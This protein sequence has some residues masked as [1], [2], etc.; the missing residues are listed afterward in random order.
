M[1]DLPRDV[2]PRV[3]AAESTALVDGNTA[4]AVDAYRW[5]GDA[6]A[7]RS[8][9][10]SPYSISLALAMTYAGAGGVTAREMANAMHY[11]LPASRLEPAFDAL[12]LGLAQ[13]SKE[14]VLR[15]AASLWGDPKESYGRAF[16]DT[17]A[18]DFGMGIRL[19]DFAHD[20][21][22]SRDRM[23][24]W[25]SEQTD[26]RIMNLLGP[27]TIDERTR[28]VVV[29]AIDFRG[30]WATPFRTAATR[31]EAFTRA[32][33]TVVNVP[34]MFEGQLA[35]RTVRT[36]EYDAVELPYEGD[37]MAMDLVAPKRGSF[38][39]FETELTAGEL[40]S[41]ARAMKPAVVEL[42]L[43]KFAIRRTSTSLE[44]MLRSFGM[45][46]AFDA[47][48]ADFSAIAADAGSPLHIDD[49]VHA[50]E[51]DVDEQGTEASAATGATITATA[52]F[53][54]QAEIHIDRP[55]VFLL[56]DRVT[57]TVLFIG[58]VMAPSAS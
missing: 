14:V 26:H 20:A 23:N 5:L 48:S 58:R 8:V 39:Q 32:D 53:T 15:I 27:G 37:Q 1:S 19:E 52:V 45:N 22:G 46:A 44:P 4:F 13:S 34:T 33:G 43:P 3:S 16:L 42:W 51:V 28:L 41:I 9:V 21:N 12:D 40:T 30:G 35:A 49:V 55:F 25:V 10:L 38:A 29:D 57:S 2:S 17:M 54:P 31:A 11:A 6:Q 24:A 7:G 56:R 47:G 18:A 36:S 50:A